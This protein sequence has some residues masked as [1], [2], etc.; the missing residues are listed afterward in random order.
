MDF[1]ARSRRHSIRCGVRLRGSCGQLWLRASLAD[2]VLRRLLVGA[3]PR[4]PRRMQQPLSILLSY[5]CACTS[6]C[7][8]SAPA[9]VL[10]VLDYSVLGISSSACHQTQAKLYS[11]ILYSCMVHRTQLYTHD[12]HAHTY[13]CNTAMPPPSTLL[14]IG[15]THI[16]AATH[17]NATALFVHWICSRPFPIPPPCLNCLPAHS[18]NN[19]G[20]ASSIVWGGNGPSAPS[21]NR[22][23]SNSYPSSNDH[24]NR[25]ETWP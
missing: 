1:D 21:I 18:T 19:L 14:R 8:T 24:N 20:S 23:R 22:K 13:T 4:H 17:A 9:P 25:N 16:A 10:L 11:C 5:T 12:V 7:A 3:T 6:R 2:E 15:R